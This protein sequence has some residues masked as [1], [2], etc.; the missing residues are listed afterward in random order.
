MKRLGT[1]ITCAVAAVNAALA[2]P[3]G[4]RAD[5]PAAA[6]IPETTREQSYADELIDAGGTVFSSQCGFCHGLDSAGG[7]GGPDLTRSELVAGDFRGDAIGPVIRAGRLDAEVP[8]PAFP[9][10]ASDDLEA[11]VAFIHDQKA[12]A[13]SL[14]GGRRAVTAE[15]VQSG[16]VAAGRRYFEV[17][18]AECHS[19][20]GDL[21]GIAARMD[22]LDLMR[23]MLN[24][25]SG[26]GQSV[27]GTPR[28]DVTTDDGE[29]HV[30]LLAYQDEFA[31]A[32]T[33]ADGRYRSFATRTVEFEIDDPLARH[34]ELLE[35][36]TDDDMH[37]VLTFLHTLR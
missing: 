16:D 37:D 3:P 19:A 34:A 31:I 9:D 32:L 6:A 1:A 13:E 18:C 36:Y 2:Q 24:P 17:N 4:R 20:D 8:M 25:G 7:S 12:Q 26:R 22:G 10:L 23:R 30:G 27:R 14:E 21:A 15:D 29:R 28:V 5:S 33:D 35:Q 11:I